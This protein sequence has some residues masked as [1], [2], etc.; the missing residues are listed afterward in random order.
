[1]EGTVSTT[2]PLVEWMEEHVG[3]A[4]PDKIL[5]VSIPRTLINV[6]T[7]Y[8]RAFKRF[9]PLVDIGKR[10]FVGGNILNTASTKEELLSHANLIA[11]LFVEFLDEF[12]SKQNNSDARLSFGE[13]D[14]N[15]I[16]SGDGLD[17]KLANK[18]ATKI[19]DMIRASVICPSITTLEAT[20][21][22]FAAFCDDSGKDVTIINFYDNVFKFGDIDRANENHPFGYVGIHFS[23]AFSVPAPRSTSMPS[24]DDT[25]P[26]ITMVTELQFHPSAIYDGTASCLKEQLH[27]VYRAF[28]TDEALALVDRTRLRAAIEMHYA[29]AMEATPLY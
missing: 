27:D 25:S 8:D 15:L 10:K 14:A 11:P 9:K 29:Y 16:K 24:T 19:H 7:L 23:L 13:N 21:R 20:V 26:M 4:A 22:R 17:M 1:M 12:M 6:P 2:F 3:G 5:G 18:G 28:H